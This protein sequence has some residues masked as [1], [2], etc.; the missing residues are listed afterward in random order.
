MKKL[1]EEE[2][3]VISNSLLKKKKMKK[4]LNL[5]LHVLVIQ[6]QSATAVSILAIL[7]SFD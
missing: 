4:Y 1:L 2:N 7:T 5:F 6:P 3:K